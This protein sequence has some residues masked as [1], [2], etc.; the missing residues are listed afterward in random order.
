M[1]VGKE[2][3]THTRRSRN[4]ETQTKYAYKGGKLAHTH[5]CA[6]VHAQTDRYTDGQTDTQTEINRDKESETATS[7]DPRPLSPP[8]SG[9]PVSITKRGR[10]HSGIRTLGY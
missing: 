7:I 6:R 2:F 4:K 8:P 3:Q 9:A 10:L 1:E 5:I